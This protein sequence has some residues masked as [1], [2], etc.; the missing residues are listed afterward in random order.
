MRSFIRHPS[1][2]PIECKM[3]KGLAAWGQRLRNVSFGGVAFASKRP[4][5][6][7]A[8]I[9]IRIPGVE[10]AFEVKGQVAWC[11]RE[12]GEYTVG[13]QFLD[14]DDSF[15]ARMVEQVCH[16]EHYKTQVQEE[17]GRS[18]TGEEAAQEWIVKFAK[19]FPS[20]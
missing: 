16:I 14:Q 1:D 15:R 4:M 8:E 20:I 12:Q 19:D 6:L 17:E 7:G 5:T 3:D 2:I 9:I 10:P 18:L 11:R 13:V